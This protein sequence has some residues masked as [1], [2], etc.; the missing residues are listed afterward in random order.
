MSSPLLRTAISH[1]QLLR[2]IF[3]LL[4][5]DLEH[6]D[7][8]V[9]PRTY[10]SLAKAN[11]ETV[12]EILHS[13]AS[14][15]AAKVKLPLPAAEDLL[16][17]ISKWYFPALQLVRSAVDERTIDKFTLGDCTLD[18]ALHGGIPT[19]CITEIYGASGSGKTQ[20]TL[21]LCVTAQLPTS[22]GG[23][24]SD[25]MLIGTEKTFSSARFTQIASHFY[26]RFPKEC[27]T[28]EALREGI[29]TL[30]IR[31]QETQDHI[32]SYQVPAEMARRK[33]RLVIIDSIA[34]N[35]RGD[36]T[37]ATWSAPERAKVL[38]HVGRILKK[39]AFENNAAI[40]CINQVAD[41][42]SDSKLDGIVHCT[43]VGESFL[44]T[45]G[46]REVGD[47]KVV[48]ALGLS[49]SNTVNVRIKVWRRD[50]CRLPTTEY[51]MQPNSAKSDDPT[52]RMMKV[53]FAPH[54]PSTMTGFA[55]STRGVVGVVSE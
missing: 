2:A 20:L 34:A 3:K 38:Y 50:K 51:V 30:H 10:R 26:E 49:W 47:D 52:T 45:S 19:G 36:E 33:I 41:D 5:M 14:E 15:L 11:I 31:D 9:S 6:I 23:L 53:C 48:P 44:V 18:T 42:F 7:G 17:T 40:V 43:R 24:A 28:L 35:F 22:L 37:S 29:H 1:H 39:A 55:I 46:Q 25:V 13:S 12:E 4:W 54:L 27:P 32:L 8:L 16:L 21:Q